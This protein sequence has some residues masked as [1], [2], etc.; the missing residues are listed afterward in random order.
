MGKPQRRW[1]SHRANVVPI[2][3]YMFW[4][5]RQPRKGM[6][7]MDECPM[8]GQVAS[9]GDVLAEVHARM[10]V[11]WRHRCA[12]AECSRDAAGRLCWDARL[13]LQQIRLQVCCATHMHAAL[14]QHCVYDQQPAWLCAA[15]ACQLVRD[16]LVNQLMY[17]LTHV[18][19]HSFTHS[20][21]THS[22]T[23]PR[24][25][26]LTHSKLVFDCHTILVVESI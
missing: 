13:C 7:R 23:H 11:K 3:S 2:S 22:F 9:A 17:S 5:F 12:G 14:G 16:W 26:S 4:G 21:P 19:T 25:H 15:V 6:T 8:S 24:T 1:S 10:A 18:F 20:L